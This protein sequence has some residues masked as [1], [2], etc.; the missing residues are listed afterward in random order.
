MEAMGNIKA[1]EMPESLSL[2]LLESS[3]IL[4]VFGNFIKLIFTKD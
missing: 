1:P 4:K 2:A 3:G